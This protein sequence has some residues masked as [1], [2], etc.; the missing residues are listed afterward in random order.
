MT[1]E[2]TATA[3]PIVLLPALALDRAGAARCCS[4]GLTAFNSA[5]QAKILPQPRRINGRAVWV[6]AELQA[7]LMGLPVS[8][9]LP[10]PAGVKRRAA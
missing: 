1:T 7:A 4:L 5:V 8:D 2:T 6:V 9:L 3:A 10:P